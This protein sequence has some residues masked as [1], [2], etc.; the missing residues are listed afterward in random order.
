MITIVELELAL[1]ANEV[2]LER[3]V[4]FDRDAGGG[5]FATME[6]KLDAFAD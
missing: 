4:V 3:G 5:W 6:D 1:E 2:C